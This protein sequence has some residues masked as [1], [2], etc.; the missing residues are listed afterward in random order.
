MTRL[1]RS[2]LEAMAAAL[3]TALAG[4]GFDGGDF[5]G[6]D[7]SKFEDARDWVSQQLRKRKPT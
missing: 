1:T 5:D 7:R 3:D 6:M 2:L 4:D